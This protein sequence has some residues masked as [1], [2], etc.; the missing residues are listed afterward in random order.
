[1]L[2]EKNV[3][4]NFVEQGIDHIKLFTKRRNLHGVSFSRFVKMRT[5]ENEFGIL[6]ITY[7]Q[8]I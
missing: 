1:M 7:L 4:N 3:E 8:T 5:S 2:F 6:F